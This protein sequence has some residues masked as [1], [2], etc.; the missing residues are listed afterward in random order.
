MLIGLPIYVFTARAGYNTAAASSCLP[1][2]LP[3]N[4][5]NEKLVRGKSII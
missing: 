5:F 3:L 2:A 1:L 4:T